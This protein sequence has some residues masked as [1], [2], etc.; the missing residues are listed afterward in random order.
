MDVGSASGTV[1]GSAVRSGWSGSSVVS[2]GQGSVCSGVVAGGGKWAIGGV[3][4]G[5]GM[6]ASFGVPSVAGSQ[7]GGSELLLPALLVG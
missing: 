3:A 1:V 6:G 7:T 2:V 4:S 5:T